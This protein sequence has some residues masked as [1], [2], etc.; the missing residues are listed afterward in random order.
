MENFAKQ[1]KIS[2]QSSLSKMQNS[3]NLRE[4]SNASYCS[5]NNSSKNLDMEDINMMKNIP[6][7][8]ILDYF[9]QGKAL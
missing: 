4:N 3:L 7:I 8:I 1:K 9:I 6:L 5:I 2:F